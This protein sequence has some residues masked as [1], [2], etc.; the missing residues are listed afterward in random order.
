MFNK[1]TKTQKKILDAAVTSQA[2]HPNALDQNK[3]F[4][5]KQLVLVTLPHSDPGDIEAWGRKNGDI[6]LQIVPGV[7]LNLDTQ[8]IRNIGYPY[9]TIP[10]LLMFWLTTEAI[11]TKSRRI[12]L[13]ENL[14]EFMKKMGLV[15][16]GG[17]NG[18]ITSFKDQMERLFRSHISLHTSI[19]KD[20]K[21]RDRWL[22]MQIAPS[23]ELW[24]DNEKIAEGKK[25]EGWSVK[26]SMMRFVH[27][28]FH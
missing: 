13:G 11:R 15:S 24:W 25:W 8:E 7:D 22:D 21:K 18:S 20:G 17:E 28:Q 5:C 4:L 3:A 26:N 27:P 2:P 19:E 9:G 6:T 23:T 16:T 1:V 10:R 14:S 12:D